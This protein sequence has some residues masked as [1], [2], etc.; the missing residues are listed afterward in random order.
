MTQDMT[1]VL[2]V[3]EKAPDL[4]RIS[5][6]QPARGGPIMSMSVPRSALE[7]FVLGDLT[8]E[9]VLSDGGMIV[10][11]AHGEASEVLESQ[12]CK[13]EPFELSGLLDSYLQEERFKREDDPVAALARLAETLETSLSQAQLALTDLART[14]EP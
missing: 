3:D 4:V 12:L 14:Q 5:A 11:V 13:S 2:D 7:A 9:F 1:V 8:L 10:V 6:H